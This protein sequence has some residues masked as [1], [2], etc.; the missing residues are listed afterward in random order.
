MIYVFRCQ[1]DPGR[2]VVL[3]PGATVGVVEVHRLPTNWDYEPHSHR[4]S[5][6]QMSLVRI[7]ADIEGLE[8][9]KQDW[10]NVLPDGALAPAYPSGERNVIPLA[11]PEAATTEH[12]YIEIWIEPTADGRMIWARW[13][14]IDGRSGRMYGPAPWLDDLIGPIAVDWFRTR[15]Q[16]SDA[17]L[18]D[19]P[20]AAPGAAA[21]DLPG[22]GPVQAC[23][24]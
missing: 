1:G 17:L 23:P 21:P 13:V 10:A 6:E 15:W 7:V 11:A 22:T 18:E 19:L 4:L 12:D 3:G 24:M 8:L 5:E 2:A 20:A 9:A 16:Q 14:A